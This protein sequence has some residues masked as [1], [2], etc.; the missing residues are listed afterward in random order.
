[1]ATA[2]VVLMGL[3]FFVYGL[4]F[5]DD[6]DDPYLRQFVEGRA[7]GPIEAVR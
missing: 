6:A 2:Y 3:C 1:M 7:D 4:G 5:L